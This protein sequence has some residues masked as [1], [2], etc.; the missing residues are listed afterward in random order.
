[1][2][3]FRYKHGDRP[4]EGYTIEYGLGRGGFG[5]VYYAVSDS[6][7]EVALKA[8]QHYEDIELR[9]TAEC[10]NL[11]SPHLVTI[12]D[13]KRNDGGEPF[14]IME[15]VAG[16]S[17]RELLDESP[18]GLGEAKAAFFLREI[19]K[20]L[21]ELH[22]RGVVHRDLKPHNIFYEDGYVK[23][24]DY[25]LSKSMSLTHRT[26]HTMT[27][28]TV[29]Y[30][31]PEIGE[32][33]YD[34]SIDIYALG[35]V[36]YE[37][38]T[39]TVPFVGATPGEVMMKHLQGTVDVSGLSEPFASVVKKAT[40][41]D[42]S[43]RFGS[44]GE[45]VEAVFG[46]A[47]IAASVSGLGPESLTMVADRTARRNRFVE[48]GSGGGGGGGVALGSSGGGAGSK[49]AGEE[50]SDAVQE[51][52]RVKRE[53]VE[54]GVR[55][56]A[57]EFRKR[58]GVLR[59]EVL[60]KVA[61]ERDG[62]AGGGSGA[63]K[64]LG[65]AAGL[66]MYERE[67]VLNR[68]QRFVMGM[69]LMVVV[70]VGSGVLSGDRDPERAGGFVFLVS[71]MGL[72][73]LMMG[74][75]FVGA[76]LRAES[77]VMSRFFVAIFGA[78]LMLGPAFGIGYE[79]GPDIRGVDGTLIVLLLSLLAVNW[80][81]LFDWRREE[82]ISFGPV[83]YVVIV[84]AFV[85]VM[86]GGN[87]VL[88]VGT[89]GAMVLGAQIFSSWR[90]EIVGGAVEEGWQDRAN[91]AVDE[92]DT[93]GADEGWKDR[94]RDALKAD[95][96]GDS[97]AGAWLEGG[98]GRLPVGVSPHLRSIVLLVALLPVMGLICG[99]QR[100]V[101]GK[102]WT[103]LL[104]LFTG[105]LF[106]VGQLYDVVMISLG[107]FKDS[108]GRRV[109]IWESASEFG[110]QQRIAE[111]NPGVENPGAENPGVG[112][113]VEY[114]GGEESSWGDEGWV[115]SGVSLLLSGIAGMLLAASVVVG[116]LLFV[117]LP[118]LIASG[119]PDAGAA[120]DLRELW[121]GDDWVEY[122]F[123]LGFWGVVGLMMVAVMLLLIARRGRGVVHMMRAVVGVGGM[124]F[125]WVGL[126]A[127]GLTHFG[128]SGTN[129]KA[130]ESVME[131]GGGL[132][133]A[134][135]I[136][137]GPWMGSFEITLMLM[138]FVASVFV[139]AWPSGGRQRR[140]VVGGVDTEGGQ[141]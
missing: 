71:M 96:D 117:D 76:K 141:L 73:G 65:K 58:T 16:P 30:M 94:V 98:G 37:M 135:E 108:E 134:V 48:D 55:A 54:K 139:L 100:F 131:S 2:S 92:L 15:Y 99:V 130:V 109:L 66:M 67:D 87:V 97:E 123:G 51:Y 120:R 113:G 103:G 79:S 112:R 13:I 106:G 104:W 44:V 57:A 63:M 86:F 121:G 24:G 68:G 64:S 38:L 23:V 9:G 72:F 46:S 107:K 129:W 12:F 56:K 89:L 52:A 6:G 50:L 137:E 84:G 34:Q 40:A 125:I 111:A 49:S 20:G 81:A 3:G 42:V 122:V 8:V 14:V 133:G 69:L 7:R 136:L 36:L 29:H 47:E 116:T 128:L 88:T 90:G 140:R 138:G 11:K 82:R 93:A 19:A 77:P 26:S 43:E 59:G 41:R 10:M 53:A 25:S 1:M 91:E 127:D 80:C 102:V 45:M 115:M 75:R 60:G 119:V 22:G 95:A 124:W 70:A 35:V 105:G 28:G 74:H 101:V 33:C 78:V 32:G 27:V 18:S 110:A 114:G 5:E 31:A 62:G 21:G 17:L 85:T 118:G 61:Q 132:K 83:F 126:W 39:G 4:L